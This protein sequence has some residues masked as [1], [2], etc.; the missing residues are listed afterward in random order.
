MGNESQRRCD[1]EKLLMVKKEEEDRRC[2]W[3][4]A[5][6]LIVSQIIEWN[7]EECQVLDQFDQ[8]ELCNYMTF[9]FVY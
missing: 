8:F 9:A 4:N 3:R 1:L 7:G 2:H 6:R 5:L